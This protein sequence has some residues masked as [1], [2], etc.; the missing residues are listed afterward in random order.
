MR[1]M[2]GMRGRATGGVL[3]DGGAVVVLPLPPAVGG[4]GQPGAA[5]DV[6]AELPGAAPGEVVDLVAPGAPVLVV[7]HQLLQLE[8]P[9]LHPAGAEV[10]PEEAGGPEYARVEPVQLTAGAGGV[11]PA[12]VPGLGPVVVGGVLLDVAELKELDVLLHGEV[13]EGV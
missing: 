2:R 8:V 10:F 1:G 9:G 12:E 7:R 13:S 11:E 5:V 3:P 4:A 6:V